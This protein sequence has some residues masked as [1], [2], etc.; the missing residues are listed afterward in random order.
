MVGS[1]TLLLAV[2]GGVGCVCF[3][4]VVGVCCS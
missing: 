2:D 4:V 1:L 3:G